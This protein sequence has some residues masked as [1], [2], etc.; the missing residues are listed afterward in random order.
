[1]SFNFCGFVD[2]SQIGREVR[3]DATGFY[4]EEV[5]GLL[6]VSL[7]TS[8]LVRLKLQIKNNMIHEITEGTYEEDCCACKEEIKYCD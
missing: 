1:M 6:C 4:F 8:Y 5:G 3:T 2:T 7:S